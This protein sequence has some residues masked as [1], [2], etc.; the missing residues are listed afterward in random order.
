VFG[1]QKKIPPA[2]AWYTN[3][4]KP[5]TRKD[6]YQ[7][8]LD[9]GPL[10]NADK[11]YKDN[12]FWQE[13]INHPSYDEFWQKRGL[14]KHYNKVKPAVMLVGGWF[15]AEDL[16]GRWLFTKPSRRKIQQLIILL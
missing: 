8:L 5:G 10:K 2:K 16:T 6:G 12:F 9:L 7:F 3:A 14:L 11:Y 4:I 13:T 15:D 1:V